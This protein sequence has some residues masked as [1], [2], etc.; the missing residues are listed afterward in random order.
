MQPGLPFEQPDEPLRIH[1]IRMRRARR[2][3]LRVRPDG[4]LRVTIPRGGSKSEALR[5]ADKHL[6]W[7]RRQRSRVLSARRPAAVERELRARAVRE[8]PSQLFALAER[9][10]LAVSH[11]SI[12]NQRSRWGSCS[13]R[14]HI[15]LN[16]RLLL[17]PD[18]VREY[19]LIH[20]LMHL[21]QA[22]H[23]IRFWR[24]VEAACPG[25]REAERWLKAHGPSLF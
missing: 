8:L 25:F 23:S 24:L 6:D 17:M 12:R 10:G 7:A 4:D 5:F 20:E 19:I 21:C 18:A 3:V 13:P 2:Y 16:F 11:V 1:F 22:N 15:A 9:H 14:G